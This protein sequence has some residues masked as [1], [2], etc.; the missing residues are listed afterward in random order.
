MTKPS[1]VLIGMPSYSGQIHWLTVMSLLRLESPLRVGVAIAPRRRVDKARNEIVMRCLKQGYDYLFFMDDDNPVPP[2]TLKRFLEDDKDIVCAPILT[3]KADE[4]GHVLCCYEQYQE[5]G[6]RFYRSIEKFS[7]GDLHQ[8]DA[9]GMGCTLI[10]RKVL[11]ELYKKHGQSMFEFTKTVF[12]EPV[13]LQ[14]KSCGCRTMSEDFEFSERAVDAGFEIW[15]DTRIRPIHLG[16]SEYLQWQPPPDT[17]SY[18]DAI[19]EYEGKDTW[20]KY[21]ETFKRVARCVTQDD[22]VLDVGCG[23]GVLLD[24]LKP[25]KGRVGLDISPKAVEILTSKGI[26]GKVG[27]LPKIDFPDKSFDVVIATETLEHLDDPSSLLA[28]MKRVAR[29]KVIVSV[30]DNVLGPDEEKEHKQ[31]FTYDDFYELLRQHFERVQIETF[32]DTFEAKTCNIS[33]PTLLAVCEV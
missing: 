15:C 28:E 27:T 7:E 32:N 5:G 13:I 19:W 2:E 9:C 16:E 3:R 26:K 24:I 11:E 30:P 29:K 14:G 31:K 6:Y 22:M 21:P 4:N 20:R 12:D 33:L 18:W 10:K 17:A 8:I 23:A 1:T 25:C